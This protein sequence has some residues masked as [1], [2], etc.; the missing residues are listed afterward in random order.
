MNIK[1]AVRL[2]VVILLLTHYN[3]EEKLVKVIFTRACSGC[4]SSTLL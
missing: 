4:P 2:M 1:P 3:E